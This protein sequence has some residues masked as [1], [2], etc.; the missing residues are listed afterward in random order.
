MTS[1]SSHRE[2]PGTRETKN[3][4]KLAEMTN[5]HESVDPTTPFKFPNSL[6]RAC[7]HT[8][9]ER[10]KTQRSN[11]TRAERERECGKKKVKSREQSKFIQ[12]D[13]IRNSLSKI[14]LMF[15]SFDLLYIILFCTCGLYG[16]KIYFP[17][18]QSSSIEIKWTRTPQERHKRHKHRQ[19]HLKCRCRSSWPQSFVPLKL[20]RKT[21]QHKKLKGGKVQVMNQARVAYR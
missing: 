9:E 14:K 1:P 20:R 21:K 11:C 4:I 8:H 2:H 3:K 19:Q 15:S 18:T 5:V 12:C 6:A 17:H 13:A 10:K 7:T 16:D